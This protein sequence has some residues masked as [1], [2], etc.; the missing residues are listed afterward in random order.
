MRGCLLRGERRCTQERADERRHGL[1]VVK[2]DEALADMALLLYLINT[3][4]VLQWHDR[5]SRQA[6]WE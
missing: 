2:N 1:A 6:R 3:S 5:K 4:A